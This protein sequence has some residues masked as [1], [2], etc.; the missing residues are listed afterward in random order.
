MKHLI[1]LLVLVLRGSLSLAQEPGVATQQP[2]EAVRLAG[3]EAA[4]KDIGNGVI[5]YQIVGEPMRI[6]HEIKNRPLS[7]YGVIVEF[8]GCRG[9]QRPEFSSE[10]QDVV[11]DHLKTK[12][13]F[14]PVA[15]IQ[16]ALM[17]K[18]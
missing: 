14:D 12:Y 5:R 1:L 7:Q 10:Y 4:K 13:G 6:D 9:S 15:Q 18:E 11:I 2:N 8:T 17:K 3:I 16:Q